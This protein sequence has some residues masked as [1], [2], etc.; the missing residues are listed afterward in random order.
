[1]DN[2]F[3]Q[4]LGEHAKYIGSFLDRL[5]NDN[6]EQFDKL[7]SEVRESKQNISLDITPRA[8]EQLQDN[9]NINI[10]KAV[11]AITAAAN[12]QTD[13]LSKVTYSIQAVTDAIK[14][15]T[16]EAYLLRQLL[17]KTD[18]VSEGIEKLVTLE[19]QPESNDDIKKLEEIKKEL[20]TLNSKQKDIDLTPI[21]NGL[22]MLNTDLKALAKA[23]E[24]VVTTMQKGFGALA[25]LL[26]TLKT[27]IPKTWKMDEQQ[28]RKIANRG[29]SLGGSH[30]ASGWTTAR[31]TLTDA[32]TEYQYTF[33]ANTISYTF[34]LDNTDAAATLYYSH[35]TGLLPV[36]GDGS[37]YVTLLAGLSA[38]SQDNIEIGGKSIY[39]E[40]PTA[41]N[42]VEIEVYTLT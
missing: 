36:S 32:N 3:L 8:I 11:Q 35:A 28:L 23:N 24:G 2:K 39:F 14:T 34:K 1:M 30:G 15:D 20:A 27:E 42:V 12:Q 40:S 6:N 31:V 4:A 9:A 26:P 33:P 22:K 17:N 10:N 5:R 7:R 41:G 13:N 25:E 38:K 21:T 37:A 29:L 18:K 19:K 16:S